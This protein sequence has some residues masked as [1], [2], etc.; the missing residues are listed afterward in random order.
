MKCSPV[1]QSLVLEKLV[2]QLLSFVADSILASHLHINVQKRIGINVYLKNSPCQFP[3][4][5]KIS[6]K[7]NFCLNSTVCLMNV[8]LFQHKKTALLVNTLCYN[9]LMPFWTNCIFFF[10]G[11]F[12]V[13]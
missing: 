8:S 11:I 9:I 10:Q 6:L 4:E 1:V 3:S 12:N 7:D 5:E 2:L 13:I